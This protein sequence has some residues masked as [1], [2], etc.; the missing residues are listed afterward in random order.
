[1]TR[2]QTIECHLPMAMSLAR[3][4]SGRGE[5]LADLTQVAALGLIKAVDRYDASRGVA[6]TSY[7]IPTIL[8]EIKR[9]FRDTAWDVRV[10]R[11][12]QELRLH[13]AIATEDLTHTLHHSPTTAELAV[14]L[15][16][17]QDDV[18]A[19]QNCG[20]AYRT[21]SI[22]RPTSDGHDQRLIDLLGG[23]DSDIEAI[24]IRQMLRTGLAS[25]PKREQRIIALRYVADMTQSQIA[26]DLGVSQMHI[27]RLLSRSLARLRGTLLADDAARRQTTK[28]T[29]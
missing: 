7:A 6:F 20:T 26:A 16:V 9:H 13:L 17:S 24:N 11:R 25:L 22:E 3:R 23:S 10:P 19:A 5:P 12:L 29:S 18:L 14:H 1:M 27:S 4:F 21:V 8:G 28:Q 15:E 2:A